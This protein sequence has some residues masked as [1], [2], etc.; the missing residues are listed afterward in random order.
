[1]GR[2]INI[3]FGNVVNT[4]K[5]V[6]VVSPEAA[7]IKRLVQNAKET[8]RTIDATQGRRTKAVIITAT[9]HVIL[10][11]LQPETISK[12]FG[13]NIDFETKGEEDE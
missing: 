2:L 3:G 10:S 12:R 9:D 4:S 8:G 1:L 7:P 6:A 13:Q 11:A 5:M